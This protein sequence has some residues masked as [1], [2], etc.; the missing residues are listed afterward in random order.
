[1]DIRYQ[2]GID[3]LEDGK[4]GFGQDARLVGCVRGRR[5]GEDSKVSF[6]FVPG[7]KGVEETDD[8][9]LSGRTMRSTQDSAS[10]GNTASQRGSIE[11]RLTRSI[12]ASLVVAL[13]NP[14]FLIS[15]ATD[16]T[17]NSNILLELAAS[18]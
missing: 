14:R 15:P 18:C 2:L 8:G 5:G 1:V 10:N 9:I 3:S 17:S 11:G 16:L 12:P 13:V 7:P 6:D 4:L